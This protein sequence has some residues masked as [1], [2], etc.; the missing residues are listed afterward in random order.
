MVTQAQQGRSVKRTCSPS[1][2]RGLT[3]E[4]WLPTR[5]KMTSSKSNK[6]QNERL[7]ARVHTRLSTHTHGCTH[8]AVHTH[9]DSRCPLRV[10]GP[11]KLVVVLLQLLGNIGVALGNHC[12]LDTALEGSTRRNTSNTPVAQ[13]KAHTRVKHGLAAGDAK[14]P[15]SLIPG[16]P[17]LHCP[18]PIHWTPHPPPPLNQNGPSLSVAPSPPPTNTA[19]LLQIPLLRAKKLFLVIRS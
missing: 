12:D 16:T 11:G 14:R 6:M 1:T 4:G 3:G 18:A 13:N 9:H 10:H 8:T 19:S 7:P 15:H 5:G 17:H 2:A